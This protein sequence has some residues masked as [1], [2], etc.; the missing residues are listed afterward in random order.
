[1]HILRTEHRGPQDLVSRFTLDSA[2][3]FLFGACVHS[4]RS[5]LPFPRNPAASASS[6]FAAAA[7]APAPDREKGPD[8]AE[9]FTS[10]LLKAEHLCSERAMQD[11]LWPLWEMRVDKSRAHMRVVDAYLRPILEEALVKK[12]RRE[13]GGKA[14][15][16]EAADEIEDGETL[17]DHLVK[18][19]SGEWLCLASCCL[20]SELDV[21]RF[22]CA[23]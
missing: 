3:E 4:L 2:T 22:D 5:T 17:L 11:K 15:L 8:E 14:R 7:L 12:A 6:P 16:V 23:A 18:Y 19:T 21:D 13:R 9:A 10:A 20:V 1:M